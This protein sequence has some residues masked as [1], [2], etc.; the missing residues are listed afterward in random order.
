M[1]MS[2][3][4]LAV[5]E[6]LAPEAAKEVWAAINETGSPYRS[7]TRTKSSWMDDDIPITP[8]ADTLCWLGCTPSIMSRNIVRAT[9]S[10]MHELGNGFRVLENEPCCGEPL[11]A[12]GLMEEARETASKAVQAIRASGVKRLVTSCGGCYTAFTSFYPERLGVEI[13]DVEVQHLSQ[14]LGRTEKKKLALREPLRVTYHDPC[15][16]GR[17]SGVYDAPREL[18]RSIEGLDLVEMSPTRAETICCGGGGGMWSIDRKMAMEMASRK[19]EKSTMGPDVDAVVTSCPMCYNNFRYTLKRMKSPLRV[20]EL[21]EVVEIAL[22][23]V[24]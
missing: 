24:R 10:V 9:A 16:L 14:F 17:H 6:G 18:L 21:S 2:L 5:D 19:L 8:E 7:R 1:I 22:K 13:P 20:Y 3:R 23:C 15:S 12:L 4:Q 11:L